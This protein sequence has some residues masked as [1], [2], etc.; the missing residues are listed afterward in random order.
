MGNKL[1]KVQTKLKERQADYDANNQGNLAF[2]RPG[3][4]N[5]KKQNTAGHVGGR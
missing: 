5:K 3:S 4:L 1:K 2:K